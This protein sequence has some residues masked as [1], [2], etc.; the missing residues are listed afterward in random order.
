M[1]EDIDAL[2]K[3]YGS[4]A[5]EFME[6]AKNELDSL[7]M[8]LGDKEEWDIVE[9]IESGYMENIQSVIDAV[10]DKFKILE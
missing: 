1:S 2:C 10:S 5:V 8:E 9:L 3:A 4:K 6:Q 7:Q